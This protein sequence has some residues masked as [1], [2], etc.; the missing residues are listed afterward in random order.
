M[1]VTYFKVLF[2]LS[3]GLYALL[4]LLVFCYQ[5]LLVFPGSVRAIQA[6]PVRGVVEERL[7]LKD[8][9]KFRIAIALPRDPKAVVLWFVGNGEGLASC[10]FWVRSLSTER[11]LTICPEYP[12]YEPGTGRARKA[13]CL[14]AA[15]L[16]AARAAA[17]AKKRGLPLF[18]GGHSL[19]TFMASHIAA[20][21]IA[22]RLVLISPPTSIRERGQ[23][24]FPILPVCLILRHDF[25]NLATAKKIR[26][27]TLVLHGT[28]DTVCPIDDGRRLT[29][30]IRGARL[31]EIRGENHD[32]VRLLRAAAKQTREF[33]R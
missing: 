14:E 27:P 1:F 31:I 11:F 8:G 22:S 10:R 5:D 20:Q 18:V 16:A 32:P 28:H 26:I 19:G 30:A 21:G 4:I 17:E 29:R 13:T 25:D 12:G 3:A 6:P 7:A 2:G 33:L 23:A 9:R 15:D 24:L